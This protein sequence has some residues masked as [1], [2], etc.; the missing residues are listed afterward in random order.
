[1]VFKEAYNLFEYLKEKQPD[2][3]PIIIDGD[4]LMDNPAGI[5]SALC[6]KL[7]IPYSDSLLT[8]DKG[9]KDT[10]TIGNRF[11][12]IIEHSPAFGHFQNTTSFQKRE[13]NKQVAASL[14]KAKV[15]AD[16]QCSVDFSMPYYLKMYEQRLKVDQD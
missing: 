3:N 6:G 12:Q 8:W 1:M 16:I 15:T 13:S 10:W 5:L 9:V 14:G 7:G 4:D 11:K 2:E